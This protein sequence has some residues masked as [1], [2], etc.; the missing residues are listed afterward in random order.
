MTNETL[1]FIVGII[2]DICVILAFLFPIFWAVYRYLKSKRLHIPRQMLLAI[3]L[4]GTIVYLVYINTDTPGVTASVSVM[5]AALVY[6]VGDAYEDM[7]DKHIEEYK[8][9]AERAI[10]QSK[11]L[12]DSAKDTA[13]RATDVAERATDQNIRLV[14]VIEKLTGQSLLDEEDES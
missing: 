8:N 14:K 7:Y 4:H 12:V 9:V 5:L 13:E 6:L 11:N 1:A 3:L 10:D 2:A